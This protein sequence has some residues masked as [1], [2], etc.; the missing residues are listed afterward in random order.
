MSLDPLQVDSVVVGPEVGQVLPDHRD[1]LLA[2]PIGLSPL[3]ER[4]PLVHP[5]ARTE[6]VAVVE[7]V[8]LGDV[9]H[10]ESKTQRVEPALLRVPAVLG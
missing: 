1:A 9:V 10:R 8:V 6:E 5:A 7:Y 2:D 4:V 3:G